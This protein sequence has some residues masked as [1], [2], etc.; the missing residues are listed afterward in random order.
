MSAIIYAIEL[1]F[2]LSTPR[3]IF[4]SP[5]FATRRRWHQH[6]RPILILRFHCIDADAAAC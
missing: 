2:Q 3:T 6:L 1:S 4:I 5:I